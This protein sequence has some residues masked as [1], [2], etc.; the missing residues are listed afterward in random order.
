MFKK[1]ISLL[2]F[3]IWDT[4]VPNKDMFLMGSDNLMKEP[5]EAHSSMVH[6]LHRGLS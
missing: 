5:V 2:T 3:V 4:S 1:Y 6:G